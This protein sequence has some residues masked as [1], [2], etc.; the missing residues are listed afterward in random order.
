MHIH[1]VWVRSGLT[2]LSPFAAA[3]G[4]KAPRTSTPGGGTDAPKERK[5]PESR[6]KAIKYP[7]EDLALDPMSIHDGRVLRRVNTDLPPLPPKPQPKR[8]LPVPREQFD[9]FVETWNALNI[10][11]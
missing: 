11:A 5:A 4:A 8:T 3:D 9:R 7:I 6:A 2:S 1:P 10:F